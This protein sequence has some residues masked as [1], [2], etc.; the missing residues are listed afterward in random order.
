MLEVSLRGVSF[1]Y[2]KSTFEMR[3]LT[4]EFP[5]SMHTAVIGLPGSGASTLLKLIAGEI[6]PH[7]GDIRIGARL[8][9]GLRTSRRPLRYAT[10]DLDVPGRWSV[11]HALIAAVRPRSLDRED[12]HREYEL[13]ASKW[14]VTALLTR[15]VADLSSS[16][17]TRVHLA[18]LELARPAI[19]VADHLLQHV[20]PSTRSETADAIYRTLR[21][22]GATVITAPA[23][24]GELAFADSVVVLDAG[25]IVQRG[26]PAE[27]HEKPV[28]EAVAAATGEV[29][30]IPM[31]IRGKLVESVIGSWE[32]DDPP[33]Q[34]S[35][36]A[37]VRPDDFAV[38]QPGE[39]SDL[40]FSIEEAGF[41]GGRW[42]ARGVLTG[43]LMLRVTLPRHIAIHKGK[44]IAL[45]YNPSRFRL[46]ARATKPLLGV[47]T[48]IVPP[49]RETL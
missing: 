47:P 35:G 25:T 42:N 34:G 16:E 14:E 18:R 26:T 6:Q 4:I 8:V 17:R 19:V 1:R 13:A 32:I 15:R 44:L 31:T 48:D 45:R 37:L 9:N 33:F 28:N 21:V 38:A 41:S 20:N 39:E 10:G 29:N 5:R 2:P 49:L 43:G 22:I 12:R 46:V 7:G 36:A 27:I 11:Q 3:D 23:A 30:I 40:V 24:E